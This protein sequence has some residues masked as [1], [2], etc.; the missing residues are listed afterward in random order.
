[1]APLEQKGQKEEAEKACQADLSA[2]EGSGTDHLDPTAQPGLHQGQLLPDQPHLLLSPRDGDLCSGCDLPA[3]QESLAQFLTAFSWTSWD[4]MA[5]T[6]A[7]FAAYKTARMAVGGD[8][9]TAGCH[10]G[11]VTVLCFLGG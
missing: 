2:R 11:W 3:L 4:P 1:M 5:W 9:G 10:Q 8:W 7:L 6:A